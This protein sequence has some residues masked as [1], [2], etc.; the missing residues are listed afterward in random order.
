[1]KDEAKKFP[2]QRR[3]GGSDKQQNHA[4]HQV[5]MHDAGGLI[6]GCDFFG[7]NGE[8]QKIAKVPAELRGDRFSV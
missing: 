4:P 6:F 7:E 1:V 3:E 2:I 8:G 5:Y